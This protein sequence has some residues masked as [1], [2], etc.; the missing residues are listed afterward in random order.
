MFF[1]KASAGTILASVETDDVDSIVNV[2]SKI[3]FALSSSM[4]RQEALRW[5]FVFS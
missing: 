5:Q 2:D 3:E 4:S 1:A